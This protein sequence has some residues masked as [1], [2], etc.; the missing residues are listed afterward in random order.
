MLLSINMPILLCTHVHERWLSIFN[1]HL[2]VVELFWIMF[3]H[4]NDQ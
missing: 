1:N 4:F 2:W 3:V